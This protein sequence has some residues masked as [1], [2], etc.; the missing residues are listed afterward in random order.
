VRAINT[1]GSDLHP[2]GLAFLLKLIG[3]I[4]L[5]IVGSKI[6][7]KRPGEMAPFAYG[8]PKAQRKIRRL[9]HELYPEGS[10]Y[11]VG[12]SLTVAGAT[13]GAAVI[14]ILIGSVCG[15]ITIR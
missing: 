1:D 5:F 13:L 7:E 4:L 3:N 10:L 12:V 14:A 2:F 15:A 8:S 9:Y 11:T 6:D